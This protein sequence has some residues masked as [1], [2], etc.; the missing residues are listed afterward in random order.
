MPRAALCSRLL[1]LPPNPLPPHGIDFFL[2][3]MHMLA[4]ASVAKGV[5]FRPPVTVIA[6]AVRES[7][8]A[9]ASVGSKGGVPGNEITKP[10]APA[11]AV[12][13]YEA[14]GEVLQSML[15][16]DQVRKS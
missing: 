7:R 14:A 13:S 10:A 1:A 8:A 3:A 15:P 11:Q 5:I 4:A 2:K 6:A 12:C 16:A 9:R